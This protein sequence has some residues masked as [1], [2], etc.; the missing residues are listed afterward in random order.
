M[1]SADCHN[2]PGHEFELPAKAVDGAMAAR[3]LSTDLPFAHK[4]GVQIIS[5][6]YASDQ[7]AAAKIPHAFAAFYQQKYLA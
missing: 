6:A 2:R 5:A 7:D 3:R 4:T 1:G